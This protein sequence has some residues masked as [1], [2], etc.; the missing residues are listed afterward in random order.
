MH[1]SHDITNR[2]GQTVVRV[3]V[4]PAPWGYRCST[5]SVVSMNGSAVRFSVDQWQAAE[6][7]DVFDRY[8]LYGD[9]QLAPGIFPRPE[10]TE[11]SV[12]F[13]PD[14]LVPRVV[15]EVTALLIA[16]MKGDN[17]SAGR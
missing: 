9:A 7:A 8:R 1:T 14:Q 2:Q 6:L 16:Y 11:F 13:L 15:D 12:D 5:V 4:E 10:S 17:E 3:S